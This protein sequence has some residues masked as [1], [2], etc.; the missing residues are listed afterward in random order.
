[1]E[2]EFRL[3]DRQVRKENNRRNIHL[4]GDVYKASL[5]ALNSNLDREAIEQMFIAMNSQNNITSNGKQKDMDV[6]MIDYGN[7]NSDNNY[8]NGPTFAET[9]E[10]GMDLS[11]SFN[12]NM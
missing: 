6:E 4:N 5:F 10:Q 1:M 9:Y 8:N 11:L 3:I 2:E 12:G 7:N